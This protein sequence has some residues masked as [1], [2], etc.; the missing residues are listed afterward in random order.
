MAGEG[1]GRT[2]NVYFLFCFVIKIDLQRGS[3]LCLASKTNGGHQGATLLAG[4]EEEPCSQDSLFPPPVA[5][6]KS[7][8][9]FHRPTEQCWTQISGLLYVPLKRGAR[10]PFTQSSNPFFSPV[11]RFFG[12]FFERQ[13]RRAGPEKATE[14]GVVAEHRA[15]E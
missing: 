10:G 5:P 6:V 13:I 9:S 15:V 14:C 4:G 7:S 8:S 3:K 2:P 12:V 1:G 11:A